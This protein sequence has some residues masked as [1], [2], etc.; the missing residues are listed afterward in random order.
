MEDKWEATP[1]TRATLGGDVLF[2]LDTALTC[3]IL[4]RLGHD[5]MEDV[6]ENMLRSQQKIHFLDGL[7]K[8]GLDR[9]ESDAIRCAK[10]HA[11]SNALAGLKMSYATESPDKCWVF[12]HSPYWFDSPR[13][14]GIG[15][16]AL[17]PSFTLRGMRG[18]HANNGDLLGN[19][20]LAFVVTH[21]VMRG[22]PFDA[23]YFLDV[24]R[25]L[26]V[27]ERLQTK[28]GEDT[29]EYLRMETPQ[30]DPEVWPSERRAKAF[31]NLSMGY[32]GSRI[33]C[34]IRDFGAKVAG[35]TLE[36]ALRI[37]LF[38]RSDQLLDSLQ[39]NRSE[40]LLTA[41]KLFKRFQEICGNETSL[42]RV[43]TNSVVA[44]L[45]SSRLHNLPEFASDQ[46]KMPLEVEAAIEG[47]W[48][49]MCR[50]IDRRVKVSIGGSFARGDK[51]WTWVFSQE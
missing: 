51:R 29:P 27:D 39:I 23:G 3:A 46:A 31:L 36:H 47:A 25:E 1:E 42:R 12:Y 49:G 15:L 26:T 2:A 30:F 22:E 18:W 10:Y 9:E 19:S 44:E 13:W 41:V 6:E 17:R 45:A 7:V 40:P 28:F 14:P 5:A 33:Y 24:H 11:F 32:V 35:E 8:L 34:L 16:A 48:S 38:Q 43:S 4:G 20:G 37:T 50:Y 21:L